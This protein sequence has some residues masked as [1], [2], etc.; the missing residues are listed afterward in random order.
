MNYKL[1]FDAKRFFFNNSGL[2]NYSRWIINAFQEHYPDNEYFLFTP[3]LP[4]QLNVMPQNT[5]MVHP[6]SKFYKKMG[7][8]WRS[9]GMTSAIENQKIDLYNGLS[10]ELPIGIRKKNVRTIVTMHDCIFMRFPELFD[11]SYRVIFKKKYANALRDA[12]GIVAVSEQTR[13]D[14]SYYFNVDPQRI[15]TVYQGC[16]PIYYN[17]ATEATKIAVREKYNLPEAFILYVGT[18][19]ERKNLLTIVKAMHEQNIDL[20]LIAIGRATK[21]LDKIKAYMVGKKVEQRV[22]FLHNVQTPELPAMY[23]MASVFVYPSLFEGFGIPVLEALNSNVPV[24][25]TNGSCFPEVGG[26]AAMYV[27]YGNT[28]QMADTIKRVLVDTD[29]QNN[30]KTS[31]S[32]QALSFREAPV[33]NSLMRYYEKYI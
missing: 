8:L 30:M 16:N 4:S 3:K 26:N 18:I 11:A 19:E 14:V 27:D 28:E 17:N 13:Q 32:M 1:G 25:T 2:G 31:G 29:L 9:Y 21:Y 15:K 22:R 23:Q 7:G 5:H 12:D 33:I 24:I 6:Q 20:P 10:H